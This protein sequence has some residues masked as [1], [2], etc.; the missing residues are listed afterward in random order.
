MPHCFLMIVGNLMDPSDERRDMKARKAHYDTLHFV[1]TQCKEFKN[2][3]YVGSVCC[4]RA[5]KCLIT[6]REEVLHCK[7]Y[8]D[9][10]MHYRQPRSVIEEELGIINKRVEKYEEHK[11]WCTVEMLIAECPSLRGGEAHSSVR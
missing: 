1:M 10:G 2:G 5:Q 8:K 11:S 4:E 9:D 6:Y 7:N 3:V